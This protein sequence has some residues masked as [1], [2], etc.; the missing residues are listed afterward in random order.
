MA[1]TGWQARIARAIGIQAPAPEGAQKR[2]WLEI[3][4]GHGEMTRLLA[5]TG[6]RVIAV[7]LDPHLHPRLRSLA[8]RFPQI[9]LAAGDIL[10]LDLS[11]L[12]G[13]AR[14]SVYGNL[15]YYITSPI[16]HRLFE[17]AE[18]LEDV[19]VVTQL[20]VAERI[21]ALPGSRQF[22]YLSVFSQFYA[23]PEILLRI[24]S[25][26][27]RPPPKVMSALVQLKLPGHRARFAGL[28]EDRFFEFVKLCFAH[29]RKTLVNNL[30]PLV[31][32]DV[33]AGTL[34]ELGLRTDAR[35][36]QL[37]VAQFVEIYH[38]LNPL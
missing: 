11:K 34:G 4:A 12:T 10:A 38:R 7:E 16:L 5:A 31:A 13:G 35:A 14:F 19:F 9:E 27:F 20:E 36:E 21:A 32:S 26:T 37:S 33:A 1:D 29:K 22:G 23:Q 6:A 30:R 18:T 24:P 28:D 8:A 25:A 2:L 15:P 3:G 17:Y